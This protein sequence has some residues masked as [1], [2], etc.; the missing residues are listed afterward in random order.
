MKKDRKKDILY[1]SLIL[2]HHHSY[3][4]LFYISFIKKHIEGGRKKKR[5]KL[6]LH[7]LF[8]S[9][10]PTT[11]TP[12]IFIFTGKTKTKILEKE[13]GKKKREKVRH[14]QFFHLLI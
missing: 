8:L 4:P 9:L 12:L 10:P 7:P 1:T 14:F 2:S 11:Q 5:R 13:A 6:S 3:T